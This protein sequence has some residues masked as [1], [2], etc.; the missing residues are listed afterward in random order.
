MAEALHSAPVEEPLDHKYEGNHY[1]CAAQRVLDMW[2]GG[3]EEG[4]QICDYSGKNESEILYAG[5]LNRPLVCSL[6]SVVC[7]LRSLLCGL[8]SEV[9]VLKSLV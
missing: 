7:V 2:I 1:G 4:L 8:K 3:D 6:R 9:C 5:D